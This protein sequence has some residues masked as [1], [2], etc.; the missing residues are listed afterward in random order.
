[1]LLLA[2]A[3]LGSFLQIVAN[4]V[5]HR[6]EKAMVEERLLERDEEGIMK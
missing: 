2:A 4:N 6:S 3:G 5:V 1:M